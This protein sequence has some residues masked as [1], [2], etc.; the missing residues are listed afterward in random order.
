MSLVNQTNLMNQNRLKG[1]VF[2]FDSEH[3]NTF[4]ARSV[5]LTKDEGVKLQAIISS[6]ACFIWRHNRWVPAVVQ[7]DKSK[8]LLESA[9]TTDFQLECMI[10]S[11]NDRASFSLATPKLIMY[12]DLGFLSFS[13][14]TN[15]I[16]IED[17]GVLEIYQNEVLVSTPSWNVTLLIWEMGSIL[18]E[19]E[20]VAKVEC[21]DPENFPYPV[22]LSFRYEPKY[23]ETFYTT[24]SNVQIDIQSNNAGEVVQI[25]YGYGSGWQS[26]TY[27]TAITAIV[28]SVPE[29]KKLF[30][31]KKPSFE[32]VK[33]LAI[34]QTNFKNWNWQLFRNIESVAVDEAN[35]QGIVYLNKLPKLKNVNLGNM[36]LV[37][38][39]E[40]G[41]CPDLENI[42]L[43]NLGWDSSNVEKLIDNLWTR[44][45][46]FLNP[47]NIYFVAMGT[48]PYSSKTT[49]QIN[50]TG[51]YAGQGL[52]TNY[53][54][55]ILMV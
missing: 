51:I 30:R 40:F 3:T 42:T 20:Y 8:V 29:G 26:I 7:T 10:A 15:G 33:L 43:N 19:G 4:T 12:E 14:D 52:I 2:V 48:I 44:R 41:I 28:H 13:L 45:N 18:P 21:Y 5:T 49:A 25:D 11:I 53:G 24:D 38:G 34:T 17:P 46:E 23:I 9:F 36:G 35:F 6:L 27:G 16:E 32:D 55:V 39:V 31:I 1:G 37:T 54:W 50:G 47:V 22:E